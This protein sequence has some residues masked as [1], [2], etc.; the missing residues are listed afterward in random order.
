M[1]SW[2]SSQPFRLFLGACLL[3]LICA[4]NLV[5]NISGEEMS[6]ARKGPA[7]ETTDPGGDTHPFAEIN[8]DDL[9]NSFSREMDIE[10]VPPLE[11]S[12]DPIFIRSV[13]IS[14]LLPP[15]NS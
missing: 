15:P 9:V 14:P 3:L 8:E 11:I 1:S 10:Q 6:L 5:G 12:K 13:L 4:T 2:A 7:I